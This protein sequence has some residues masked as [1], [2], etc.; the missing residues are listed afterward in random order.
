VSHPADVLVQLE[1]P[2]VDVRAADLALALGAPEQRAVSTLRLKRNGYVAELRLLGCSHQALVSADDYEFSELV[3]CLP[4]AN[5]PLPSRA[6]DT[7]NGRRYEFRAETSRLS[8]GE[9]AAEASSLT[10]AV[11]N[12]DDGLVGTFPRPAGAFTALRVKTPGDESLVWE[13]WHG[14]PQTGEI[15]FTSSRIIR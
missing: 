15:V 2:F 7:T 1:V 10:E 6:T 8:P 13:T 9:Y 3:A 12:L 11:A 14:Y 4:G 5:G